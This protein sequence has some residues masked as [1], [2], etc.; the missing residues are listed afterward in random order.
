LI[1]ESRLGKVYLAE[2]P[3]GKVC[4]QQCSIYSM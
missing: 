1:R 3:E 4:T 2:F